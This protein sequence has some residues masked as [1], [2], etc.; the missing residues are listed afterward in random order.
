M[1]I[2]S[3]LKELL[4]NNSFFVKKTKI[5]SVWTYE[6]KLYMTVNYHNSGT[7]SFNYLGKYMRDN[8]K[9]ERGTILDLTPSDKKYLYRKELSRLPFYKDIEHNLKFSLRAKGGDYVSISEKVRM[10]VFKEIVKFIIT[11]SGGKFTDQ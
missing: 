11:D 10:N 5:G 6:H 2:E 9:K 3:E 1:T 4:Y 7:V 8:V